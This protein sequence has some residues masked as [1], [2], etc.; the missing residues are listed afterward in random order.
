M[1]WFL[2]PFHIP[3]GRQSQHQEPSSMLVVILAEINQQLTASTGILD[4]I[5]GYLY[6]KATMRF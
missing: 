3:L 1:K 2:I 4:A 6:G 5:A